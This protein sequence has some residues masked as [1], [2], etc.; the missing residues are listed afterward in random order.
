LAVYTTPDNALQ[1][2]LME[3]F[4]VWNKLHFR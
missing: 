3:V 1:L 4:N 2:G